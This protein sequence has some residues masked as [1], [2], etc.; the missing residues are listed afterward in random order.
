MDK[1][2]LSLCL[3]ACWLAVVPFFTSL[4]FANAVDDKR[5]E[6]GEVQQKMQKM[7]KRRAEARRE[8]EK[9][10]DRLNE[11]VG[12]LQNL[13][14]ESNRL[15]GR[16]KYLQGVI[17]ENR[18]KLVKAKIKQAE[19][20]KIYRARLREIYI[21]GQINY[22]DVLLGASDFSDFSSRMYL[23]QKIISK[24]I[25]LLEDLTNTANEIETRQ[26]RLD[27]ALRDVRL[28][29]TEIAVKTKR[30]DA[31]REER[32][33]LLYKAQE[34]KMQSEA[35]YERL[36]ALS[37]NIASMLRKMEA[38]GMMGSAPQ[39]AVAPQTPAKPVHRFIWPCR[40][41][42]TSYFGWRKHPIFKT[43][44]YHSGMDIAVGYG[45]PIK[46][47]AAG[48]VIYSG[49]LGGYGYTIMLDHGGG[50]VTLYAHN[51]GLAVRE[52]QRVNQGAVVAYAG[53]TGYSTG[54][55]CHFEARLHGDVVEPLNYLPK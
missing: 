25:A 18:D 34:E 54:P 37:E 2:R 35:E 7:E 52:G 30:A 32:A 33:Q 20:M 41:K 45:T 15:R 39:A 19:R 24:D 31:A 48:N 11:V 42:I 16:S 27:N 47:A 22:L 4:A 23:L 14:S 21:S 38:N 40:G 49:W 17:E 3:V 1:K 53:S 43:T 46:A 28:T 5:A 29:Q 9:A 55:H 13:Q 26:I 51:R 8:A 6:L 10:S 36:L 50:L 44:K 12:R